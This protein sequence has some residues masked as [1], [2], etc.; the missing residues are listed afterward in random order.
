MRDIEKVL[1]HDVIKF[2]GVFR[3]D[4]MAD[5]YGNTNAMCLVRWNKQNNS[6]A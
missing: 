6:F 5:F 3:N 4:K 2:Y 1:N